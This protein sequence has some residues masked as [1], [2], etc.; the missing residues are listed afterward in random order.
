MNLKQLNTGFNR[1]ETEKEIHL[2][3]LVIWGYFDN[4]K[5]STV[6]TLTIQIRQLWCPDE[7]VPLNTKLSPNF[8]C[9]CGIEGK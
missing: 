9:P 1:V 6:D 5:T 7:G 2:L 3:K 4:I 8:N